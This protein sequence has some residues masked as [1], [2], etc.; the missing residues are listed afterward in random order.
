MEEVDEAEMVVSIDVEPFGLAG[1]KTV[2]ELLVAVTPL[3]GEDSPIFRSELGEAE[4]EGGGQG[5]GSG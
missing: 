3:L 2:S 1:D 4:A 5:G